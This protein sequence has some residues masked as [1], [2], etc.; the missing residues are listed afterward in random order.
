MVTAPI[1]KNLPSFPLWDST[2]TMSSLKARA[3][4][5]EDISPA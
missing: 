2:Q 3:E 5:G 1:S 4:I